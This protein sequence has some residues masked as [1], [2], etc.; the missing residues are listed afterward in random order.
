MS[1]I[2]AAPA[3][4]VAW[5]RR[6]STKVAST[7][8]SMNTFAAWARIA[9]WVLTIAGGAPA[10]RV[11]FR[12]RQ[13]LDALTRAADRPPAAQPGGVRC[14]RRRR[15]EAAAPATADRWSA[16]STRSRRRGRRARSAAPRRSPRPATTTAP[17]PRA[18]AARAPPAR[19]GRCAWPAPSDAVAAKGTGSGSR[20]GWGGGDRFRSVIVDEAGSYQHWAVQRKNGRSPSCATVRSWRRA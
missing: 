7:S 6:P 3:E 13:G 10:T 1:R 8:M 12:R 4:T 18:T 20:V 9:T 11:G 2:F 16:W 14:R 17:A 5:L 19:T 15:R